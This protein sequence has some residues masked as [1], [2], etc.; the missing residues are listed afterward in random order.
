MTEECITFAIFDD[1][2]TDDIKVKMAQNFSSSIEL[3]DQTEESE[4][5]NNLKNLPLRKEK[6]SQLLQNSD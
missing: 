1:S 2:I 4:D 5:A 3:E 6:I